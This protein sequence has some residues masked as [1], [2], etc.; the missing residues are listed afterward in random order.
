MRLGQKVENANISARFNDG[1]A[2]REANP[3]ASPCDDDILAL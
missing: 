1:F 3:A 2:K